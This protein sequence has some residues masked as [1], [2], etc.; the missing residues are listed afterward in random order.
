[1]KNIV[2]VLPVLPHYRIDLLTL[3]SKELN[4]KDIKLTVVS[5]TNAGK[6]SVKEI[7]NTP[8]ELIK[9]KTSGVTVSKFEIQWQTGLIRSILKIKADKVVILYHAGKINHNIL[10]LSL[11]LRKIPYVLWG[12]GSGDRRTDLSTLQRKMKSLFKHLFIKNSSAYLTYGT[13]F[14]EQLQLQGYP[15]ERIF[16][17]QNTINVEQIYKELKS[18]KTSNDGNKLRFL[19]VGVIFANKRLDT[20]IKAFGKL[21]SQGFQFKFDIVGNGEIIAELKELATEEGVSE[22]VEFHGPKYA[23]DLA[24]FFQS[25][26]VFILPGTGGLA[27]NE[28]MAYSL[29]VITTPGDG[30]AYDL[31]QENENGF[32]L[33]FDYSQEEL[34]KRIMSFLKLNKTDLLKM[35][36]LSLEV[37]KQKATLDNMVKQIVRS[38]EFS[39]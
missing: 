28:A 20:A 7:E 22:M 24:A 13:R 14:K 12:S 36:Q 27:I 26:D 32:I 18:N 31:V 3:L 10:L 39:E 17:A 23:D 16:V 2:V 1:M 21:A 25:A 8:F 37:V 29:P 30:T 5:G 6:K 15:K 35:G 38:I 9:N 11:Q 19:F 4:N 34:E 33:N